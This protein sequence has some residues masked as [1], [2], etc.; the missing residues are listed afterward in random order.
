MCTGEHLRTRKK[1]KHAHYTK[2]LVTTISIIPSAIGNKSTTN[3]P[4]ITVQIMCSPFKIRIIILKTHYTIW[5]YFLKLHQVFVKVWHEYI[6]L[7]DITSCL[8]SV[9]N[10]S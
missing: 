2:E 10:R 7:N 1:F 6:L 3:T 8:L 4:L 9:F 5:P